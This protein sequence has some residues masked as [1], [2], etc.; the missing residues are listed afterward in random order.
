[1]SIYV[2]PALS[3]EQHSLVSPNWNSEDFLYCSFFSN[4]LIAAYA[5]GAGQAE[6]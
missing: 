3:I 4:I 6:L 1:M 5:S 2:Y